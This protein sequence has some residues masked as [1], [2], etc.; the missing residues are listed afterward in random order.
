MVNPGAASLTV[1]QIAEACGAAMYERD[2][3][4]QAL[5]ITLEA[6]RPGYAC[7]KMSV[8]ENMVNGH[9]ICHGGMTFSLAD[10][11]FAYACNSRNQTTVASACT[12]DFISPA[13]RGDELTAIAHERALKGRTGI[14]DILV[15]NQNGDPIAHFR[16]RSHRIQGAVVPGLKTPET[17]L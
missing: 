12:I 2:Y 17:T 4:A 14:Y 10:T 11:A 5:G 6:I 9:N 1:Q 3:A 7:M 13:R 16:G 8:R 15:S